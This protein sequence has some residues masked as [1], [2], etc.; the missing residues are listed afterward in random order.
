[1]DP[2]V[3]LTMLSE[4]ME[5]DGIYVADVGQ[6]QIW[7]CGYHIVKKGR[8][9]TTGG[10][11]TMGYSIPAAM[12]AKLAQPERQ[13]IAVCG[14][15]SFQMSMMELATMRQHHV[16]AKIV[17]LKNNYLGM[18]REFQHYNYKDNYSVVD[19]SGSPDLEKLSSAYDMKFLRLEN[20]DEANEKIDEFLKQDESVLMECIIDPMDLV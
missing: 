19:L 5:D 10:M 3:F 4:K 16:P 2:S 18:V 13:V 8:F 6:N 9:L 14:D 7:S 17:V 15:G 12:G 11:G 1:V 20:M